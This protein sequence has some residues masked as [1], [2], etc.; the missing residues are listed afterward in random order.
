MTKGNFINKLCVLFVAITMA[1]MLSCSDDEKSLGNKS[2]RSS[3]VDRITV[4]IES[5]AGEPQDDED[6]GDEQEILSPDLLLPE[7][8]TLE[9]DEN[10][11]IFVSQ[12]TQ[13]IP[14]FQTEDA[15]YDYKFIVDSED[16]NWDEGYN[17]TPR[18]LADPLEWYK[19]SNRGTY[20][21]YFTLFALHFPRRDEIK[22]RTVDGKI[23]YSVEE[24][25]STLENLIKSDVL[26]AYHT[27]SE[28]FNRLRFRLFHLMTYLRIRLYVPV[29]NEEKKTGFFDDALISANL[30]NANPEFAVDWGAKMTSD[31]EGP[32][33]SAVAGDGNIKMYKHPLKD[34]EERT[35][36][37][38]KYA[39]F[40]QTGFFDQEIDGDEDMVR[41][42]DFSVLIPRQ[43]SVLDEDGNPQNFAESEFL[44]FILRSNSGAENKY[45]FDQSMKNEE[46]SSFLNLTPGVFQYMELYVPRVGNKIICMKAT[47]K[48]W[49]HHETSLPLG[50]K[51]EE[52]GDW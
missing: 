11:V 10:S 17:F 20:G 38:I 37:P 15:I 50:G 13:L 29:Y 27:T 45:I 30:V 43:V 4:S 18:N 40:L 33:I 39:D 21:G 7:G 6:E 25:Q 44:N 16:A 49:N 32:A 3:V 51:D 2:D 28:L 35:P 1:G 5:R 46:N 8:Y 42:Y 41:V 52:E 31:E 26:G 14:A 22:Q 34:G 47:L 12:Q 23:V 19:I 9:F 24:D 36:V 48:P